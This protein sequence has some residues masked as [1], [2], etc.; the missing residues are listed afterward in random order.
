[1]R[2]TKI[3]CTLGPSVGDEGMIK[4]LVLN[5]M[6]A[7]RFNFS[8]GTH[9]SHLRMLE[10]LKSV[11][12]ELNAPVA[13][14]LDTKGPEIRIKSFKN[15]SVELKPGARFTLTVDDVAGDET[16]VSVTYKNLHREIKKGERILLDDG[17]IELR[18]IDISDNDI[19]CIV[20]NGGVISDNKGI[21]TPD[22]DENLPSLTEKDIE[23]IRFGIENDFDFIAASFIRTASD[24]NEIRKVLRKYGGEDIG[25][26]SKIENRRGV[27]NIES[28]IEASDA[29][30][31]A[32]GDLGVEI[33]VQEVPIIQKRIIRKCRN[34]GVPVIIATQMLDSMI[35]NPRPTR[36]EAS[37]VANA[38]FDGASTLMLS[39]ETASGKYPLES[40]ITMSDIAL[41]T[42]KEIDY[43]QQFRKIEDIKEKTIVNAIS[44][45]CCATAMGLGA[46]TIITVTKSG[47]TARMISRFRPQCPIAAVTSNPKVRRKLSISWGIKTE[48]A[49][50]KTSTD[51]LFKTGVEKAVKMKLAEKGD[52][53]VISAGVPVGMSGTTNIVKAQIV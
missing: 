38:V 24:V 12:E 20:Q 53:V 21:N 27:E 26:I 40:L 48:L 19:V 45:A 51:E 3:I 6:N 14:I 36:A 43:W 11:R 4:K 37:D 15:G 16:R 5:G 30:M 9:E 2:K 35:R 7:A 25:I 29:I 49:E 39:G 33:P 46:K 50:E 32:R 31:V 34:L 13:T 22:T 18:V 47:H 41:T 44:R 8:H 23:D 17:L 42:E 52:I 1:M 28:I 10:T